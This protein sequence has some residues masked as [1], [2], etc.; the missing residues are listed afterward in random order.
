MFLV[1]ILYLRGVHIVQ[2]RHRLRLFHLGRCTE[3]ARFVKL[4]LVHLQADVFKALSFNRHSLSLCFQRSSEKVSLT[5]ETL[6]HFVKRVLRLVL[7]RLSRRSKCP[8]FDVVSVLGLL[9]LIQRLLRLGHLVETCHG[10][11]ARRLTCGYAFVFGL[12]TLSFQ[13]SHQGFEFNDSRC[14][15]LAFNLQLLVPLLE[16]RD[17]LIFRRLRSLQCVQPGRHKFE[18]GRPHHVCFCVRCHRRGHRLRLLQLLALRSVRGTFG[19]CG[20]LTLALRALAPPHLLFPALQGLV[21]VLVFLL[22]AILTCPE[23]PRKI[24]RKLLALAPPVPALATL[25]A[26]SPL[27]IGVR[28]RGQGSRVAQRIALGID[29]ALL[30]L[31]ETG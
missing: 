18:R 24:Q 30:I 27:F 2:C 31:P 6:T 13:T 10:L 25:P 12:V 14:R 28:F 5:L 16:N 8:Y 26:P 20:I 4:I 7:L 17:I 23:L 29:Q 19:F 15:L 3:C 11:L 22:A 1:K 21:R 9:K